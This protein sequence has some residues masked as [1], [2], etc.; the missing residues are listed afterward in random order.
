MIIKA[1]NN[2]YTKYKAE[3]VLS[4]KIVVSSPSTQREVPKH[5]LKYVSE[6]NVR[7]VFRYN[8][9]TYMYVICDHRQ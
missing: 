7:K 5:Q 6:R 2:T 3:F 4:I 8:S 1:N 9:K